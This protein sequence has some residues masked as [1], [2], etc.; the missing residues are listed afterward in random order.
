VNHLSTISA[1]L[2]GSLMSIALTAHANAPFAAKDKS[3]DQYSWVTTHNSYEK[4]NQ[5]LAEIP[6]QLRDGV[7]GFMLDIYSYDTPRPAEVLRVCHKTIACYG[8]W[9]NQLKNEFIPFLK[10]NPTEVVTIFL[11]TYAERKHLQTV[12]ET[13]P[14]L[15]DYSFNP[16]NFSGSNWPTLGEMAEKNN[17]LI[18]FTNRA[19]TSGDYIVNGKTITVLDEGHWVVS[20][21]WD[22][23]G[24]SVFTH[25]W[26]C[27]PRN[28]D[29]PVT[30]EKVNPDT[31]KDSWN[32]L[33]LMNQF[34][35]FIS[36]VTDSAAKD[37]NLTYLARRVQTCGK[38]P[39]F[40]GINN[41]QN[42]DTTP[43]TKALSEGGI[44]FWEGN[45]ADPKQDAV[46][47]VPRG[48][49][50]L[51]LPARGCEN[52]EARSLTLSGMAKGTRI[53]VF[54]SRDGDR[55]DDYTV[56][57]LKRNI[58]INE[59]VVLP[60]F[61]IDRNT[62]TYKVVNFR[63]NGLDGKVSRIVVDGP[64]PE[65]LPPVMMM[66]EGNNVSQNRVCTVPLNARDSFNM[67]S[68]KY[69]CRNDEVRSMKIFKA[70]KGSRMVF[71]GNPSGSHNQGVT[72]ITILKDIDFPVPINSFD[73]SFTNEYVRVEHR[74]N[75]IDGKISHIQVHHEGLS[76]KQH[77]AGVASF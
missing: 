69:G 14:E 25:D 74:G 9:S 26:S 60:S 34:H 38:T 39:N 62:A 28:Q 21:K 15:A 30:T 3:F 29:L 72:E 5:N 54:D 33:F 1:L 32:R 56:V 7:R 63:N 65:N 53:T 37:N 43:Y 35:S 40:I 77:A 47:V 11:E 67:K 46:C 41:Y 8:P 10:S 73:R 44:Y 70:T 42:G 52:D 68:H 18:L 17:R 19:N 55:N 4:I 66:Y 76:S 24:A 58:D 31:K 20:N 23:L 48:Q 75:S 71:A 22:S 13:I 64:A 49:T 59:R 50:T 36:T 45:N 6:R 27:P 51:S 61:E 57:H 16:K 2:G 12:F